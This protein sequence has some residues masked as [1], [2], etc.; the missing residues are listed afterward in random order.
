M[1]AFEMALQAEQDLN[2]YPEIQ[3]II[4]LEGSHNYANSCLRLLASSIDESLSDVTLQ[5]AGLLLFTRQFPHEMNLVRI[6]N[7]H[8]RTML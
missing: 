3:N 8:I 7:L 5:I 2:H 6:T 4:L 1:I